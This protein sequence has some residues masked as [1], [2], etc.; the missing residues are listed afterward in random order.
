[1]SELE[2]KISHILL[3]DTT[4]DER[5]FALLQIL[6]IAVSVGVPLTEFQS[7]LAKEISESE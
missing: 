7:R 5:Q 2:K 3:N 1:M 4:L 6:K